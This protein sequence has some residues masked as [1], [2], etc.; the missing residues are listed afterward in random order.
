MAGDNQQT[1]PRGGAII[2]FGAHV[3]SGLEGAFRPPGQEIGIDLYSITKGVEQVFMLL[4]GGPLAP[5]ATRGS[6][7]GP[8]PRLAVSR[9]KKHEIRNQK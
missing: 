6:P 1:H 7:A 3:N 5:Q 2:F 8:L 4:S 9:L